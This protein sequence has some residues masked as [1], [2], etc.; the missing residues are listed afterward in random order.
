MKGWVLC[1]S[2]ADFGTCN[3]VLGAGTTWFVA[4]RVLPDATRIF[5]VLYISK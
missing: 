5:N 2:L 3:A 1:G 4:F